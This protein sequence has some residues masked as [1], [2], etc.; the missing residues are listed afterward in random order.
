[1]YINTETLD[2]PLTLRQVRRLLPNVALPE[3]PDEATLNALGFATVQPVER[4]TGDVVTEGQPELV[5][6]TWQQTWN[7]R[8]FTPE[9]IEQRRKDAVPQAVPALEA[10]LALDAA[11]LSAD[12]EVWAKDPA[13]TF[14]ERAFI[15][16]AQNWRRD[17]PTL[18]AAAE[19]LELSSEQVDQLFI[20]ADQALAAV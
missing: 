16:K 17:D 19:A 9:E 15:D 11:G 13:R 18:Q 4:P 5:D 6:G 1:M 10:L 2:Y 8:E 12:Y 3:N 14:A 7:V 20:A